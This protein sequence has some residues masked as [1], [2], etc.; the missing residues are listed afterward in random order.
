MRW[1]AR[2]EGIHPGGGHHGQLPVHQPQEPVRQQIKVPTPRQ[3]FLSPQA[4]KRGLRRWLPCET[5]FLK[6]TL[7]SVRTNITAELQI[8]VVTFIL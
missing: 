3:A 5:D 6:S 7:I 1:S 8:P 2:S 4:V